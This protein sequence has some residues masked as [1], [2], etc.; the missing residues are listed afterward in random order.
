MRWLPLSATNTSFAAASYATAAGRSS[1]VWLSAPSI[2]PGVRWSGDTVRHAKTSARGRRQVPQRRSG[3]PHD[4][5]APPGH[6]RTPAA[7]ASGGAGSR[8][9]AVIQTLPLVSTADAARHLRPAI[10]LARPTPTRE[11]SAGGVKFQ[12]ERRRHAA[13][14][15]AR[16][17]E[18]PALSL[19]SSESNPRCATHTWF[20]PSTAT[21]VIDPRTHESSGNGSGHNGTTR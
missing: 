21:P 20:C 6:A 9:A 18:R 10:A 11:Q 15:R 1:V 5:L 17:R 16:R 12:D 4:L 8:P 7:G 13:H 14:R 2:L 3:R 19:D